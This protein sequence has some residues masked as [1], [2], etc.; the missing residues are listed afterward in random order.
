MTPIKK[1]LWY[2][3]DKA[4]EILGYLKKVKENISLNYHNIE[5]INKIT[6]LA[7][8]LLEVEDIDILE[9]INDGRVSFLIKYHD[10]DLS[11]ITFFYQQNFKIEEMTVNNS[12]Q[13]QE[14][15]DGFTYSN[16]NKYYDVKLL[17]ENK[18]II[19]KMYH[20]TPDLTKVPEEINWENVKGYME[21]KKMFEEEKKNDHIITQSYQTKDNY[22]AMLYLNDNQIIS[23]SNPHYFH[24]KYNKVLKLFRKKE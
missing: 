11:C 19:K 22:G 13:L 16:N 18:V 15:I 1:M 21:G 17:D 8:K 23:Q 5:E 9:K 7:V 3:L 24:K 10:F 2:K 14:V 4:S 20:T 6:K 12:W